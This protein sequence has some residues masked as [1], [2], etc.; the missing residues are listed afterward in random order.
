ML[1]RPS[2]FFMTS[3]IAF[4]V[5]FRSLMSV[6]KMF[7]GPPLAFIIPLSIS[8]LLL[9]SSPACLA[10]PITLYPFC[11]IRVPSASWMVL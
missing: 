7:S 5:I 3:G 11:A 9:P 8:E 4:H 2:D 6:L 1:S 10:M